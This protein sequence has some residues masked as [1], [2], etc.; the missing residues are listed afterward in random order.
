MINLP[1]GRPFD[2]MV[3]VAYIEQSGRNYI[4]Q[5][6]QNCAFLNHTKPHSLDYWLRQY[7]AINHD[8]RQL[9]I[10]VIEALVATGLFFVETNLWCPDSGRRCNGI[11]LR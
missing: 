9:E 4:I 2:P 11:R 7:Y 6:K 5:G 1:N 10:V 8:T 3:L